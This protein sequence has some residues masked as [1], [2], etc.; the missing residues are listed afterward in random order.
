MANVN[1]IEDSRG[2]LIDLEYFCSDGC[3]KFSDN[4]RG[5]YG[6]VELYT[7]EVCQTCATQLA[8]YGGD[9]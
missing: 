6:C 2:D 5:W 8:Y 4:Y 9:N 7:A 3:A 1:L